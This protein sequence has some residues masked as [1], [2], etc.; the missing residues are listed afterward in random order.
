MHF[1]QNNFNKNHQT[2]IFVNYL[3]SPLYVKQI[4][5][6]HCIIRFT[7]CVRLGRMWEHCGM[8]VG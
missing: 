1:E 8:R 2:L 3:S 5:S 6:N 4:T 7:K